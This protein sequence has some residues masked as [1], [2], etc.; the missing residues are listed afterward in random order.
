VKRFLLGAVFLGLLL[1]QGANATPKPVAHHEVKS[2]LTSS[3]VRAYLQTRTGLVSIAIYDHLTHKTWGLLPDQV[4][5][6]ASIAKVDIMAAYLHQ[7][8][9]KKEVLTPDNLAKLT[10]MIEYS[11]NA[12]ASYFYELVGTCTGLT[13]FNATIPL[14]ATAP[15]CPHGNIYGWG[16]TNT[17]ALDQLHILALFSQKNKILTKASQSLG[18]GLMKNI[19][20]A[21]TWGVSTGP[22][23][24]S[25]V[26]FKNGWTPVS[27]TNEWQINSI[28]W[29]QGP[30]RNY[31][32]AILTSGNPSYGYGITT[33]SQLAQLIWS[34]M[35]ATK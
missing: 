28:G 4:N 11:S 7:L 9:V 20:A 10:Q 17:T 19:S 22:T 26:A 18:L 21:D 1:P 34:A 23:K 32:I 33:V 16:I 3:A 30:K 5:H 24:G 12:D 8:Q 2:P 27:P 35:G 15:V 29:I 31:D 25:V 13:A 6:A 14:T